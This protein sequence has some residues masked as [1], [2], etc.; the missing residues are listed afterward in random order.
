MELTHK[1]AGILLIVV[2]AYSIVKRRKLAREIV[3]HQRNRLLPFKKATEKEHSII[4]L[5]FGIISSLV[6]VL[7]LLGVIRFKGF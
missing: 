1:L 5:V 3:D 7:S 4:Y 6:G 2:G